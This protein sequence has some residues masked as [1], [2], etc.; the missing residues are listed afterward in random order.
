MNVDKLAEQRVGLVEDAI[1]KRKSSYDEARKT[2][3]S[4][5]DAWRRDIML[6]EF[7]D[8]MSDTDVERRLSPSTSRIQMEY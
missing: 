3:V 6:C 7:L 2:A 8:N 4:R 5:R 1:S